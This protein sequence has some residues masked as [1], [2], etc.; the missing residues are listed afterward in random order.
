MTKLKIVLGSLVFALV[1]ASLLAA[2]ANAAK[3]D[4]IPTVASIHDPH[5]DFSRDAAK[6]AGSSGS[7]LTYH[8][9]PV[10]TTAVRVQPIFWGVNWSTPSVLSDKTTGI[11][12][13]YSQYS[14]SNY[15][16]IQTQYWQSDGSKVTGTTTVAPEIIDSAT[17]ASKVTSSVLAEVIN[18]VGYS[19]LS[20]TAF[21]PVYT[22]LARG[23]AGYCAWHSY[24]SVTDGVTTKVIKF[25]FFFNLDSD[26]G[27][28]AAIAANPYKTG[29]Q[30]LV[31]VSAHELAETLTDP[32]QGGWYD[33]RGYENGDKCAWKF[34]S[35]G[36]T[37]V[38]GS[39]TWQLQGEW[40]NSTSGCSW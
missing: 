21:Y 28:T 16:A 20:T 8:T 30:S 19:N 17:V 10:M 18:K 34:N 22:D 39:T 3:P 2:P 25:G 12:E 15:S 14:G 1:A 24:A 5:L 9:G 37:L 6:L 7:N 33:N 29:T 40:N 38:P 35:N 27:C 23:S 11:R 13:F 26:P 32:T 4:A 31:N 36:V